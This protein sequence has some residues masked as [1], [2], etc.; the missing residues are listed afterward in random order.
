[1]K[2]DGSLVGRTPIFHDENSQ[3]FIHK[4][5]DFLDYSNHKQF[6]LFKAFASI[7]SAT[8][9][10]KSWLRPWL[11]KPLRDFRVPVRFAFIRNP[12]NDASPLQLLSVHHNPA[13]DGCTSDAEENRM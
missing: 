3:S 8:P 9:L 12:G 5:F 4:L 1:M 11:H 2:Q 13:C 6:F 7:T 10:E